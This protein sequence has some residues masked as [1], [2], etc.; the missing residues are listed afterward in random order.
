VEFTQRALQVAG[1]TAVAMND[2]YQGSQLQRDVDAGLEQA[3]A[4]VQNAVQTAVVISEAVAALP[5]ATAE[6]A[7]AE[8]ERRDGLEATAR[9]ARAASARVRLEDQAAA[10]TL[11]M[12]GDAV[13]LQQ[14]QAQLWSVVDAGDD[15][16]LRAR[17]EDQA[18]ALTGTMRDDALEL[19]RVQAQL[20]S[21]SAVGVE[22][23]EGGGGDGAAATAAA[24]VALEE[25]AAAITL[26]MQGDAQLLQRLQ[27]QL[28]EEG[29]AEEVAPADDASAD[30]VEV[31]GGPTL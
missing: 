11:R 13:Q 6:E 19:Q 23:E 16:A 15:D 10:L 5:P 26:R 2:A 21:S 30:R 3:G 20:V 17:L 29:E 12:E 18:V 1:D 14:V 27:A 25:Q 9:A 4:A 24:R 22:V 7:A 28:V 8:A 31:R